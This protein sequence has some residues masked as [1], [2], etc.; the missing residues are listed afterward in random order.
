MIF[1]PEIL[2]EMFLDTQVDGWEFTCTAGVCLKPEIP[3][4]SHSSLSA[5]DAYCKRREKKKVSREKTINER[6]EDDGL[7]D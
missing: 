2:L 7:D 6:V 1:N 3:L 5:P 4:L